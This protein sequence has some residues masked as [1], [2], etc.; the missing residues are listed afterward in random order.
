MLQFLNRVDDVQVAQLCKV[1]TEDAETLSAMVKLAQQNGQQAMAKIAAITCRT[2]QEG[3]CPARHQDEAASAAVLAKWLS[4]RTENS[5][6]S[7]RTRRLRTLRHCFSHSTERTVRL[8]FD[9]RQR[10]RERRR[11]R[12]PL[13]LRP[14]T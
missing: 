6:R 9:N 7:S 14:I 3:W 5:A 8:E 4:A 2:L 11:H 10:A 1:S 13:S 12:I